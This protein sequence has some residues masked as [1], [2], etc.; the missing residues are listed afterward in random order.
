MLAGLIYCLIDY[1]INR[2]VNPVMLETRL[3]CT[4]IR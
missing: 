1:W 3:R 2:H 4:R